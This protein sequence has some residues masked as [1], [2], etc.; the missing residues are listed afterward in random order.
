MAGFERLC[1]LADAAEPEAEDG[2]PSPAAT[3][4]ELTGL[5]A[6]LFVAERGW[7][8]R[9][10]TGSANATAVPS[11]ETSSSSS[12]CAGAA[13]RAGWTP[14]WA[15][16]G[17]RSRPCSSRT[18]AAQRNRS[19]DRAQGASS[20]SGSTSFMRSPGAGSSRRSNR[21]ATT[22]RLGSVSR[23]PRPC[24]RSGWSRVADLA[25]HAA[26][27]PLAE[28]MTAGADFGEVSFDRPDVVLRGRAHLT[29]GR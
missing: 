26:A 17:V 12:S 21:Q 22:R 19:E 29:G 6:K 28:A 1:T 18:P 13:L 10:W 15:T 9:L 23:S 7:E 16:L 27:Q 14:P 11:T 24:A 5:H 8:A 20:K 25:A 2:E 4:N 3:Q